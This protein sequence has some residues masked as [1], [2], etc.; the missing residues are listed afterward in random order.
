[1][2]ILFLALFIVAAGFVALRYYQAYRRRKAW[3]QKHLRQNQ[4]PTAKVTT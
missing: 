2:K 1:M 3:A 4:T